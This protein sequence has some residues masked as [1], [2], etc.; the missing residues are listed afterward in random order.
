MTTNQEAYQPRL[1]IRTGHAPLRFTGALL[2]QGSSRRDGKRHPSKQWYEAEIYRTQGGGFVA[3]AT[4]RTDWA[5]ERECRW[6]AAHVSAADAIAWLQDLEV[7][8]AVAGY[9]EG[10]Q[11]ETRQ[12]RLLDSLQD[13]WDWLVG[14][15]LAQ[16][17][18]EFAEVV[19]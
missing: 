13:Q 14:E 11:F 19:A 4:Y 7:L 5:H 12:E 3:A 2:A 6:A 17:G 10:A 9:P 18:D 16:C 15:L 8:D 1:A